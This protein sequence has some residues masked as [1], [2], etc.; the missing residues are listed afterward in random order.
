MNILSKTLY[1]PQ[2]YHNNLYPE[3]CPY[4]KKD[5]HLEIARVWLVLQGVSQIG[6]FW[7]LACCL[8]TLV[9]FTIFMDRISWPSQN[10]EEVWCGDPMIAYQLFADDVVLF[11]SSNQDLQCVF[12]LFTIKSEAAWIRI[13]TL[14]S[15]VM[16]CPLWI[17]EKL[18]PQL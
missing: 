16:V 7:T 5:R 18:L 13:S 9:L 10:L 8:L 14:K 1:F 17:G 2:K 12:K 4:D 11:A 15:E 6:V 3:G